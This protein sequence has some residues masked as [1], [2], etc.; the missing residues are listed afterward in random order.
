MKPE[1]NGRDVEG[2]PETR[3]SEE[4]PCTNWLSVLEDCA[5]KSAWG[6]I[7]MGGIA[8]QGPSS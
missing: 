5:A 3:R 1:A 4:E 2:K 7:R 8:D 6:G